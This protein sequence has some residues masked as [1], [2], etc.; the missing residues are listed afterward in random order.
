MLKTSIM[1]EL[2]IDSGDIVGYTETEG[3][4]QEQ[5]IQGFPDSISGYSIEYVR[6]VAGIVDEDG[7]E[8]TPRFNAALTAVETLDEKVGK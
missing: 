8:I 6:A 2:T 7:I 5:V 3:Y 1:V 4:I